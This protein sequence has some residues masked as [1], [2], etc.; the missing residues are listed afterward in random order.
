[1]ESD[2]EPPPLESES[3]P[4]SLAAW[5]PKLRDKKHK[6]K[7]DSKPDQ[8]KR[9]V[10]AK[11]NKQ[12]KDAFGSL[13]ASQAGPPSQYKPAATLNQQIRRDQVKINISSNSETP[14][15]FS[16]RQHYEECMAKL[17]TMPRN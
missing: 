10:E 3:E 4:P 15:A 11:V 2:S 7:K 14:S 13:S 6:S 16:D 17:F 1:M 9:K 5:L 8:A 12:L